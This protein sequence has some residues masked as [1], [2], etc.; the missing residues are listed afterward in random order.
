MIQSDAYDLYRAWPY[1]FIE[2]AYSHSCRYTR[3][4]VVDRVELKTNV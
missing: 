3:N 4:Y 1:S 2:F